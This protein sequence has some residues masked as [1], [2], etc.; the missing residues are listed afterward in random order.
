MHDTADFAPE[1]NSRVETAGAGLLAERAPPRW[2][3]PAAGALMG[4]GGRAS[5]GLLLCPA[6]PQQ[7]TNFSEQL[8][9]SRAGLH[10]FLSK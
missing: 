1:Q 4:G 6:Q 5:H 10:F 2:G 8:S 7:G 9:L 3:P